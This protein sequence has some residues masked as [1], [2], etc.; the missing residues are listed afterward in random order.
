MT[1]RRVVVTVCFLCLNQCKDKWRGQSIWLWRQRDRAPRHG[2]PE[3]RLG[4]SFVVF[5]AQLEPTAAE[6]EATMAKFTS[7]PEAA[8][9]KP[10]T[11]PDA[12]IAT[13]AVQSDTPASNANCGGS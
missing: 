11:E 7:E 3:S 13:H 10:T 8:A 1:S 5:V 6:S 12:V 2:V 4:P 9:A